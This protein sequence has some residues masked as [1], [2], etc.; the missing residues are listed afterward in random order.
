MPKS[1]FG[2]T[3]KMPISQPDGTRKVWNNSTFKLI[4]NNTTAEKGAYLLVS[5]DKPPVICITFWIG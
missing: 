5:S 4:G 1:R 3:K 2:A